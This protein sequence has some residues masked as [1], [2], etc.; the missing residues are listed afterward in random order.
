MGDSG[1]YVR[2]EVSSVIPRLNTE[3]YLGLDVGA[4]YGKSTESLVGKQLQVLRLVYGVT[5]H[6]VYCLMHLLVPLYINRK[7]IIR[8]SFIADLP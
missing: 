7:A 8:K 6:P 4:V 3:V 1:W 5:M 2:N